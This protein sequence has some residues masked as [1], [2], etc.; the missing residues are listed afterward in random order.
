M[1]HGWPNAW[2]GVLDAQDPVQAYFSDRFAGPPDCITRTTGGSPSPG[3]PSDCTDPAKVFGDT[4]A[5][6]SLWRC[7]IYP[8]ITDHFRQGT[9]PEANSSYL[10]TNHVDTSLAKA[11][12]VT[13]VISTCAAA[14][15]EYLPGCKQSTI[16]SCSSAVLSINGSMLNIAAMDTC[17][18]A[19]CANHPQ[20]LAN[21]DIAGI[22]VLTSYLIQVGVTL[23]SGII[24][25]ILAWVFKSRNDKNITQGGN[26]INAANEMST[27]SQNEDREYNFRERASKL[28]RFYDAL[29]VALFEFLGAQCFSSIAISV[30][31]LITLNSPTKLDFLDQS[32]LV[33]AAGVGII[34]VTFTL[35]IL[36]TFNPSRRSWYIFT[37]S[38][39]SWIL[40][41]SVAFSQQMFNLNRLNQSGVGDEFLSS[42]E[43]PNAC[44]NVSPHRMCG[45]FDPEFKPEYSFYFALCL[46]IMLGLVIWQ[47]LSIPRFF[48][49][50]ISAV[51]IDFRRSKTFWYVILHLGA[52]GFFAAPFYLFLKTISSL[53]SNQ[54]VNTNWS[55][56]QIL[57]IAVWIPTV[58]G[59]ANSWTDGVDAARTKQ[60]PVRYQT[61][62]IQTK[63]S[64]EQ[65]S[66][67]IEMVH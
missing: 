49:L 46:P 47:L 67:L 42:A 19:I 30:A 16:E 36:A 21:S 9:L 8:T 13:S 59:F 33:S 3:C 63:S 48:H 23:L 39:C 15:C 35:Y 65:S 43:Y 12:S 14:F 64:T 4:G 6:Y 61:I 56:G 17:V 62:A 52:L 54:S 50:C 18:Q 37:L 57:A 38:L 10:E 45:L 7:V 34:P 44:G 11:A 25:V 22:G 20:P 66:S 5:I 28:H 31:A 1:P 58:A 32:A 53:F 41:L 26:Y 51:R 55:F 24:L 40:A 60:L 27:E 2:E 29:V